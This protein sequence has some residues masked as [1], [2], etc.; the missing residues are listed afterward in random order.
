MELAQPLFLDGHEVRVQRRF[1]VALT[2]AAGN[3]LARAHEVHHG[4]ERVEV[5]ALSGV[6]VAGAIRAEVDGAVGADD[7]HV[8]GFTHVTL[9]L[10]AAEVGLE[11]GLLLLLALH[12]D[13]GRR[14][15]PPSQARGSLPGILYDLQDGKVLGQVLY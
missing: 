12:G 10:L 1:V 6:D 3:A 8:P 11:L 13:Y 7:G 2:E 14:P 15:A 9:V 5:V 4:H